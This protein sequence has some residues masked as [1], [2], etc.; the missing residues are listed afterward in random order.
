M[1]FQQLEQFEPLEQLELGPELGQELTPDPDPEL[2]GERLSRY[3]LREKSEELLPGH[4][5]SYCHKKISFGRNSVD[6]YRDGEKTWFS[7]VH[8]CG[9]VWVCPVC[10]PRISER[11][12]AELQTAI[13]TG[14]GRGN[15]TVLLTQTV[16]HGYA[17]TLSET[18]SLL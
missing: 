15:G 8:K 7:G 5:V 3:K 14:T 16:S 6:V 18:T 2:R 9:S 4:R 17:D 1:Q 11:R 13:N 12:R 10:S